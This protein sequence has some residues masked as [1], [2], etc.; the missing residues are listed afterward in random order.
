MP[1][2]YVIIEINVVHS[3]VEFLQ[4]FSHNKIFIILAKFAVLSLQKVVENTPKFAE[5]TGGCHAF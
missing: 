3:F 2:Y 1:L 4:W 5:T